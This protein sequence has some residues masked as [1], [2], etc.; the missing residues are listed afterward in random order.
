MQRRCRCTIL[1]LTTASATKRRTTARTPPTLRA[2]PAPSYLDT[3]DCAARFRMTSYLT[4]L[5][6]KLQCLLSFSLPGR[7]LIHIDSQCRRVHRP[8]LLHRFTCSHIFV[9]QVVVL[10][11]F[12]KGFARPI[13]PQF[14]ILIQCSTQASA[15]A[16]VSNGNASSDYRFDNCLYKSFAHCCDISVRITMPIALIDE[17]RCAVMKGY[18]HFPKTTIY[19]SGSAPSTEAVAQCTKASSIK[20]LSSLVRDIQM[21]HRRRPFIPFSSRPAS[22][23]HSQSAV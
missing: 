23:P 20:Y 4:F 11:L 3:R 21:N 9:M 19:S 22:L 8:H 7:F 16:H 6:H 1:H 17:Y 13:F 15:R 18:P 14:P 12:L 5:V 10:Q 2:P